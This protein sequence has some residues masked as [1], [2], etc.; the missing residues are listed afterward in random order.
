MV[1]GSG[2]TRIALEYC[3]GRGPVLYLTLPA[4]VEQVRA[5]VAEYLPRPLAADFAVVSKVPPQLPDWVVLDE[6]PKFLR[7]RTWNRLKSRGATAHL[8]LLTGETDALGTFAPYL[9]Q[10]GPYTV[11]R[12]NVPPETLRA[13]QCVAVALDLSLDQLARYTAFGRDAA[14][15]PSFALLQRH[16]AEVSR[17]KVPETLALLA[18]LAVRKCAVFSEFNS[19]LLELACS[20]RTA[21]RYQV[22]RCFGGSAALRHSQVL[23][24][25]RSPAPAV[26]LSSVS[27]AG[28]GFNLGYVEALVL[29]EGL[30]SASDLRQTKARLVRVDQTRLP[31]RVFQLYFKNT[32]EE[33][34]VRA[35]AASAP[36]ACERPSSESVV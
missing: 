12:P 8:L 14:E 35:N 13:P 36:L 2:K 5:Q 3:A 26:L 32:F 19:S 33:R 17:W 9:Q 11:L 27:A 29:L 21:N 18:G 31:Q 10:L 28:R 16:R 4:L 1:M 34:L 25:Q 24:F 15:E 23:Q 20:L 30:Y 6:Y 7:T 22:Y